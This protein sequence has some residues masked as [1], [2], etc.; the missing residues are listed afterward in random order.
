MYQ[1]AQDNGKLNSRELFATHLSYKRLESR[2]S[3]E[4]S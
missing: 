4:L 1:E 2:L 3:K